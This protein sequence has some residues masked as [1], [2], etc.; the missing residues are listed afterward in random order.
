MGGELLFLR[1]D[2]LTVV[3]CRKGLGDGI[4]TRL[5]PLEDGLLE[6]VGFEGRKLR[7]QQPGR[8][9]H[10]GGGHGSSRH[11]PIESIRASVSRALDSLGRR[12]VDLHSWSRHVD[13]RLAPV[14]EIRPLP[15]LCHGADDDHIVQPREGRGIT[16]LPSPETGPEERL[17]VAERG[18]FPYLQPLVP[19]RY[20][21][22]DAIRIVQRLVGPPLRGVPFHLLGGFRAVTAQGEVDRRNFEGR[23]A[24]KEA[25]QPVKPPD[26]GGCRARTICVQDLERDDL[27][28]P[29]DPGDPF[30]IVADGSD[31]PA[32]VGAMPR[33]VLV[34]VFGVEGRETTAVERVDVVLQVLVF[35]R[36]PRIEHGDADGIVSRRLAP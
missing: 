29:A 31:D 15:P 4:D 34:G 2:P 10:M 25:K 36:D 28:S 13:F 14:G 20:D 16:I 35:G 21:N 8:S 17:R 11:E 7:H 12:A 24:A 9:R 5:C 26:D 3:F 18:G 6:L 19:G 33:I 1:I 22:D 23:L 30:L 27:T 32:H